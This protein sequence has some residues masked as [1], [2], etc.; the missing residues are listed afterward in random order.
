[1]NVMNCPVCKCTNIQGHGKRH[2]LY[3][4][5][6]VAIVGIP[7]AMLHQAATPELHRC[8]DCGHD[9]AHRTLSARIAHLALVVL[10]VALCGVILIAIASA[11]LSANR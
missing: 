5:G 3:P 2:A 6:I 9:F 1:M 10:I 4:A 7:V 8:L 11:L